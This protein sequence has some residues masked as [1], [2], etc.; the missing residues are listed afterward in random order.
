MADERGERSVSGVPFG[1]HRRYGD[2][3]FRIIGHICADA[4]RRVDGY[5]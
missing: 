2:N 3:P 5:N 4:G 1:R